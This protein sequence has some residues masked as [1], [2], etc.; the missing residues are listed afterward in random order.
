MDPV[1]VVRLALIASLIFSL[2]YQIRH[3]YNDQNRLSKYTRINYLV[4]GGLA[5]VAIAS[6]IPRPPSLW[7]H[8]ICVI[9]THQALLIFYFTAKQ[10]ASGTI[11]PF[12]EKRLYRL[13]T[14]ISFIVIAMNF[15]DRTNLT[16]FVD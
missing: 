1:T 5:G 2:W 16:W 14:L 8:S 11:V 13:T 3:V 4:S 6:S 15:A 10:V 12:F 7:L 9:A